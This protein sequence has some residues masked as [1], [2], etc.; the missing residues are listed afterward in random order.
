VGYGAEPRPKKFDAFYLS[1]NVSR[2]RKILFIDNYA[3][4]YKPTILR[5]S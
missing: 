1:Q 5:I 3:D 4:T 2:D